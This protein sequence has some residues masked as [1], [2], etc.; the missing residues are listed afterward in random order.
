MIKNIIFDIG[1]VLVRFQPDEAIP[2]AKISHL[3]S[4]RRASSFLFSLICAIAASHA[5]SRLIISFAYGI[6]F[7]RKR[8]RVVGENI[9]D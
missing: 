4:S 8:C 2:Y 5:A 3:P 7:C 1:N 6:A 9:N